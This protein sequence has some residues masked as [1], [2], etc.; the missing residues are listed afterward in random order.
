MVVTHRVI[1]VP[2]VSKGQKPMEIQPMAQR[3][4]TPTSSG[5][6]RPYV[7]RARAILQRRAR[8]ARKLRLDTRR[9]LLG[10]LSDFEAD[11]RDRMKATR[12]GRAAVAIPD[13]AT[14]RLDRILDAVGLE[15]RAVPNA[16]RERPSR[17]P[18][19]DRSKTAEITA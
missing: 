2:P 4:K 1:A 19:I 7:D 16:R 15:R 9:E 5:L 10:V 3:T 12:L 11:V 6:I 18:R 14:E 8:R 13:R 17:P